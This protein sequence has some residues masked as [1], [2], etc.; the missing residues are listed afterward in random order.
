MFSRQDECSCLS[1]GHFP[2]PRAPVK[3]C[4]S[5]HDRILLS[6]QWPFILASWIPG[7]P[8]LKAICL[9]CG[10]SFLPSS[11]DIFQPDSILTNIMPNFLWFMA[12]NCQ[13]LVRPS[14]HPSIQSYPIRSDCG[15]FLVFNP[16]KARYLNWYKWYVL[17]FFSAPAAFL[18]SLFGQYFGDSASVSEFQINAKWLWFIMVHELFTHLDHYL[19]NLLLTKVQTKCLVSLVLCLVSVDPA[20]VGQEPACSKLQANN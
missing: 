13:C 15:A 3:R 4:F 6:V 17:R 14:I 16:L 11:R 1:G 7:I 5:A 8:V 18:C 2:P 9:R 10:L 20:V 19:S 12:Y